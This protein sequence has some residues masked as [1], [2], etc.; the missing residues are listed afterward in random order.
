MNPLRLCSP[1]LPSCIERIDPKRT[2][3]LATLQNITERGGKA[4]EYYLA[5]ILLHSTD[6]ILRP[7]N[8]SGRVLANEQKNIMEYVNK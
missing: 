2:A 8:A 6:P 5:D 3:A 7:A 4:S 1:D